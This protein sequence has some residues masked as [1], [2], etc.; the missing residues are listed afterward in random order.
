MDADEVFVLGDSDDEDELSGRADGPPSY[1]A[2]TGDPPRPADSLAR[3]VDG[4][5]AET[6]G[7]QSR[8]PSPGALSQRNLPPTSRNTE[9]WIKPG[10]TLVGIALKY[11][12][13]VRLQDGF[14]FHSD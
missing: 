13:E 11:G 1:A 4:G 6:A 9:Y 7:P 8:E 3:P 5:S 2:A 14:V 12:V 10:D